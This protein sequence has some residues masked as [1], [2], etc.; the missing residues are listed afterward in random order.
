MD[1]LDIVLDEIRKINTRF[2]GM[3]ARFD[4]MEDR[5]NKRFDVIEEHLAR[6]TEQVNEF[7]DFKDRLKRAVR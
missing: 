7:D 3:E 4:G 6:I 1:K 5:F 2:D